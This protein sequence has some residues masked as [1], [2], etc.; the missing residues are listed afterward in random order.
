MHFDPVRRAYIDNDTGA[1]VYYDEE[2]GGA[3]TQAVSVATSPSRSRKQNN[4]TYSGLTVAAPKSKSVSSPTSYDYKSA[5]DG[6]NT[7]SEAQRFERL[8]EL[9][10]L[11]NQQNRGAAQ[12]EEE[13]YHVHVSDSYEAVNPAVAGSQATGTAHGSI[14]ED[15]NFAR[16]LQVLRSIQPLVFYHSLNRDEN[17][18][19]LSF[20]AIY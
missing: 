19:Y 4:A 15:W 20:I 17:G 7:E 10:V 2:A 5:G 14:W 18:N 12:L 16:T 8:F 11:E 3:D 13:L 9:A 1:V 6:S